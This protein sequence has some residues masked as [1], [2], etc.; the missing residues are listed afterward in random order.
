MIK[1]W[2]LGV[3]SM[4][5]GELAMLTCRS[6]YAYGANGSPPRIPP[7]ATLCFEVELFDWK[8]EDLSRKKDGGIV[9]RQVEKGTGF[10]T[11]NDGASVEGE[12]V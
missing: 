7:D 8:G 1:A 4:R 3:A 5:R 12:L 10:D 2:D 6:E 11:P 9:R